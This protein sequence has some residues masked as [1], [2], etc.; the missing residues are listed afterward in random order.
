MTSPIELIVT[1]VYSRNENLGIT[2][3]DLFDGSRPIPNPV[4]TFAEAFQHY[5]KLQ[6]SWSYM[7]LR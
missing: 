4:T 1:E 7:F 6:P 5:R 3:D 2:V